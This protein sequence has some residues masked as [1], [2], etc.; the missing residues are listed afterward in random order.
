MKAVMT[1]MKVRWEIFLLMSPEGV[2]LHQKYKSTVL[3]TY[4]TLQWMEV[5]NSGLQHKKS[6]QSPR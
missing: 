4:K 1:V 3:L 5:K 6:K 2:L